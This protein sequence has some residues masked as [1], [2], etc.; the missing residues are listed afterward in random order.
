LPASAA[1]VRVDAPPLPPAVAEQA[2]GLRPQG[3][4]EM[5]FLGMSIYDGWYWGHAHEWSLASPFVLDLQY[6]RSLRGSMI[7]ERSV[8]EIERPTPRVQ[9]ERWARRCA[10]S[11]TSPTAAASP[12]FVPPDVRYF[13]RHADR[14]IADAA[15]GRSSASIRSRPRA[16]FPPQL[17]GAP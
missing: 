15:R 10:G 4:G 2:K 11:S 5:R 9:L 13:Q 3:G 14:Q 12:P 16:P 7:A 17:L 1:H 8:S 6:R